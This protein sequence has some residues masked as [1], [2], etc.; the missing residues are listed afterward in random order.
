[1]KPLL[2]LGVREQA[3]SGGKMRFS[4]KDVGADVR[5]RDRTYDPS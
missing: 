1:M 4:P 5:S 2:A 3:N